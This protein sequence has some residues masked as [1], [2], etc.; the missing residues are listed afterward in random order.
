MHD[1]TEG[2]LAGALWELADAS[3]RRLEI[4]PALVPVPDLAGR[5]CRHLK[6]DPL[7]T[8]ASGALLL[9]VHPADSRAV[10]AALEAEGIPC[11]EIGQVA[12][13]EVGVWN[14]AAG[15]PLERPARDEIAR[16]FES[17]T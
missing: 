14:S 6:L 5:I 11:A 1:P 7:A 8:I 17:Q 9:A 4:D 15:Q 3:G 13:G 2:G 10:C 12:E 16:L